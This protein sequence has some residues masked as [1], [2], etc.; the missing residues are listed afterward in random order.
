M[1]RAARLAARLVRR[2]E[3]GRAAHAQGHRA[4]WVAA[5][6]LMLKGYR[7]L[8]FRLRTPRG[9]IDLLAARGG[10]LAVVEVK[11]RPTLEE[12]SA[13]VTPEQAERLAAAARSLVRRPSLRRLAVRGDIVALAPGRLPRHRMGAWNSP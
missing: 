13:A 11:L 12:A 10:V 1:N 5:L 8:G 7:I 9:E 2:R 4:E 6:W 3:R